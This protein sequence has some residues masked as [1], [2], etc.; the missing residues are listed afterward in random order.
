M[1]SIS[2]VGMVG[3][4]V[5]G[6]AHE[7]A[8]HAGANAHDAAVAIDAEAVDAEAV[9]AGA[10]GEM[11]KLEAVISQEFAEFDRGNLLKCACAADM[12]AYKS[13]EEC[14]DL[15]K[16]G[17]DWVSC[18]SKALAEM[19]SPELRTKGRC[20]IEELKARNDCVAATACGSTEQNACAEIMLDCASIDPA[21]TVLISVQCPD[22]TILARLTP[23]GT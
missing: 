10:S 2:I 16:S 1:R 8:H 9:D 11:M 18:A 5:C 3:L 23:S 20:L 21:I 14:F 7:G 6:C 19:N 12:G 22:T 13:T 17:P 15:V 4:L